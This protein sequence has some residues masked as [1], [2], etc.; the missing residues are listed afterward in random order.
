[1]KSMCN[2]M[3]RCCRRAST[4]QRCYHE[5]ASN[6]QLRANANP[7]SHRERHHEEIRAR[8][9]YCCEPMN[10]STTGRCEKCC[11]RTP[12]QLGKSATPSKRSR[13]CQE[14]A[15]PKLAHCRKGAQMRAI[16]SPVGCYESCCVKMSCPLGKEYPFGI[17]KGGRQGSEPSTRKAC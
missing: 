1:M 11:V 12:C 15:G 16:A 4:T 2:H 17:Q 3:R 9:K 10:A 7:F 5:S 8:S 14:R 6:A 13:C